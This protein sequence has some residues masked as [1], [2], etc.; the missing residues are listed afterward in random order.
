VAVV[1]HQVLLLFPLVV[2]VVAVMVVIFRV[3]QLALLLV[4]KIQ[5]QA[6]VLVGVATT[7]AAKA[8]QAWL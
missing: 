1:V 6:V 4:E 5:V 3:E 2:L 7:M 8:V